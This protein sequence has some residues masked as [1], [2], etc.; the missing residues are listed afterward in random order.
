MRKT[1]SELMIIKQRPMLAAFLLAFFGFS[2]TII[3]H[4][5]GHFFAALFF[6]LPVEI[7]SLGFG[8]ALFVRNIGETAFQISLLPFGG[9]VLIDPDVFRQT[10]IYAQ[11]VITVAGIVFNLLCAYLVFLVFA[12]A[13]KQ[14]RVVNDGILIEK[15][16]AHDIF[17]IHAAKLFVQ[18]LQK[19]NELTLLTLVRSK[20][21]IAG[22]ITLIKGLIEMAQN[23]I[24]LYLLSIALLNIN[25][26]FF[27][28]LPL[29]FLDGSRI[30][31]TT[32]EALFGPQSFSVTVAISLFIFFLLVT[33]LSH[34]K[35]NVLY[36]NP[37]NS[38]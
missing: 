18:T 28:L 4:E 6:A 1:E 22:P 27:N 15:R 37:N 38:E 34:M 8:P 16:H 30:V 36:K 35:Q 19:L 25:L 12:L 13:N 17:F 11:Y 33:I 29:P 26:A 2:A 32:V 5:C 24:F 23:G 31:Q 14:F 10:P 21:V 7:F 3:I 20:R 9:Y